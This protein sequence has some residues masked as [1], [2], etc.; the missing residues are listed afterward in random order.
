MDQIPQWMQH[1]QTKEVIGYI[2]QLDLLH[3]WWF[4][5]GAV[6]FVV[7]CLWLKWRLLLTCTLSLTGLIGLATYISTGNTNLEQSSDG[8]FIFVGGG[9]AIM[10]FFIYMVFMRGD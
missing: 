10:F 3:N 1:L 6:L 4:I 7:L 2:N 9:A 8:I 5:A